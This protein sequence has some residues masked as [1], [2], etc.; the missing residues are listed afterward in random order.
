MY[1]CSQNAKALFGLLPHAAQFTDH[2]DTIESRSW[3]GL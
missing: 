1:E 3:E 2:F